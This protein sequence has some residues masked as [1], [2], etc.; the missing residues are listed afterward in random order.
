MVNSK[1]IKDEAVRKAALDPSHSFIVEAPAGSGKTEL[2]TRRFINL[3]QNSSAQYPE[4]IIAITFTRKAASEMRNRVLS[5]LPPDSLLHHNPNR[6]KIMTIDAFCGYLVSRMPLKS[7]QYFNTQITDSPYIL[8]EKAVNN[9]LLNTRSGSDYTALKKLL[10]YL[11]NNAVRLTELCVDMLSHRDQWLP[12]VF[13]LDVISV[14][15]KSLKNTHDNLLHKAQALL[16]KN[17]INITGLDNNLAEHFL[18]KKGEWRKRGKFA[19]AYTPVLHDSLLELLHAPPEY[20]SLEQKELVQALGE[21]LPLLTAELQLVFHDEKLCD[22]IEINLKALQS[23]G[24]E[25]YPTDL[26]LYCDYQIKHLL[27]D[28]FQDTSVMQ[29][30]LLKKL[31]VGWEPGDGRTLFLVGDPMQSIYRFRKAEVKLFLEAQQHGIGNIKLTSLFLTMNFR[32]VHNIIHWINQCFE[33]IFSGDIIYRHSCAL[34]SM[35]QQAIFYH[36]NCCESEK[37]IEII[38]NNP[39]KHIGILVRARSHLKDIIILLHEKNIQ[40]KAIDIAFLN[41]H[42]VIQDLLSL[43]KALL[44]LSDRLSWLA[45][46]RAPWCGLTLAELDNI[47]GRDFKSVIWNLINDYIKLNITQN[48]NSNLM[49]IQSSFSWAFENYKRVSLRELVEKT[50]LKLRGPELLHNLQELNYANAYFELLANQNYDFDFKFFEK[51]L[52]E[53]SL[54]VNADADSKI[55][56]MTIHKSK[57][58]EFD[59]VILTGLSRLAR[60]DQEKLLLWSERVGDTGEPELLV[61]PLKHASEEDSKIYRYIKREN[62]KQAYLEL[63]RLLYVAVT[64]AKESLHLVWPPL[65][66]IP[67]KSLLGNLVKALPDIITCFDADVQSDKL[68]N[69][70]KDFNNFIQNNTLIKIKNNDNNTNDY[71]NAVTQKQKNYFNTER[72]NKKKQGIVIHEMLYYLSVDKNNDLGKIDFNH[73]IIKKVVLDPRA[74]WILKNHCEAKSEYALT[75]VLDDTIT[76]IIIDRTFI[77]EQGNRWIID[78]KITEDVSLDNHRAQLEKY[79][80]IMAL[81]ETNTEKSMINL[82]L[83]FPLSGDWLAWEF[84]AE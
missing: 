54:P 21:L 83:Y 25:E 61:A 17:N 20:Y 59:I 47:A 8:Y 4:E 10:L 11:D 50:W 16:K 79:A 36:E 13:E 55:D 77:D 34:K 19:K 65:K 84:L 66:K 43:T 80:R 73:E 33:K 39:D 38:N 45:V 52:N 44:N 41:E 18:T 12:Y 62:Q 49:V 57:G 31:T 67:E 64:R 42:P 5:Y 7:G 68:N 82:G 58:L 51:K 32:S 24:S 27:I 28:E 30:N 14:L 76:S 75:G 1:D 74:Q 78:Y 81:K 37:V 60:A 22:F 46:L 29:L 71:N 9:L 48:I 63:Q 15:E 69:K 2:L 3:L 26:A 72:L 6:L 53:S 35:D 23:L 56:I 40:Y 70:N